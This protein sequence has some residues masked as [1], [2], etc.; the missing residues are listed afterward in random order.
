MT[1]RMRTRSLLLFRRWYAGGTA[2][3]HAPLMTI[4]VVLRLALPALREGRLA[5]HVEIVEDGTRLTVRDADE[6]VEAVRRHVDDPAATRPS[7]G[8]DPEPSS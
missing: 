6:L 4:S 1:C 2:H 8:T 3:H 5:G 7:V